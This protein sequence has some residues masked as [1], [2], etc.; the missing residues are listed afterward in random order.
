MHIIKSLSII[1]SAFAAFGT[2]LPLAAQIAAQDGA[3]QT[4]QPDAA[5]QPDAEPQATHPPQIAPPPSPVDLALARQIVDLGYPE[6]ERE[7]IFFG[8]MDQTVAQMRLAIAPTLPQDDPGAVA[9]LDEWIGE[10][11]EDSKVLLGKHIPSIM[12][13]MVA[14]YANMFT[15]EELTDI[16][17]FV[18]TPS[19]QRYFELSPALIAEPSFAEANQRYMDESM[20]LLEPARDDLMARLIEYMSTREDKKTPDET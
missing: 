7:V 8:T 18:Q 1:A 2:A 14:A 10:Y 20:S 3:Q 15:T 16:L 13:G 9:I 5:A 19:G 11:I 12:D 4:L 6:A 17:A